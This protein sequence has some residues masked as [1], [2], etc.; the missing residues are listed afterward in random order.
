M[1]SKLPGT[2]LTGES[3][4]G[5]TASQPNSPAAATSPKGRPAMNLQF[6]DHDS[7]PDLSAMKNPF[8]SAINELARSE[9]KGAAKSIVMPDVKTDA[10]GKRIKSED[11]QWARERIRAAA[12]SVNRGAR[13]EVVPEEGRP[14]FSRIYFSLGEKRKYER[15]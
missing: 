11:V 8:Q 7:I 10:Q 6:D 13:T 1:A 4:T 9:N 2:A 12:A 3:K 15:S 14:G 5:P